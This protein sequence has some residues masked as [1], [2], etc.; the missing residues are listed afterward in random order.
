MLE[1]HPGGKHNWCWQVKLSRYL[2]YYHS[3]WHHVVWKLI[4]LTFPTVKLT[5]LFATSSKGRVL[6]EQFPHQRSNWTDALLAII[7]FER[8]RR[9]YMGII[10]NYNVDVL[11]LSIAYEQDSLES[12]A[13]NVQ[14]DN[15]VCELPRHFFVLALNNVWYWHQILQNLHAADLRNKKNDHHFFSRWE[16]K[17]I[18]FVLKI[19]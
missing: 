5:R 16:F 14:K 7:L 15:A 3:N 18:N 13:F 9:N 2:C 1:L 6:K 10:R 19:H 12:Y 17:S 4:A 8:T 11:K